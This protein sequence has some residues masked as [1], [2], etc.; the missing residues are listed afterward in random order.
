MKMMFSPEFL[1]ENLESTM[2]K[3]GPQ[4]SLPAK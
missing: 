4:P 2:I 3:I 1:V